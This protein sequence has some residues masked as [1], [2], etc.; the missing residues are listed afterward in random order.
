MAALFVFFSVTLYLL[1]VRRLNPVSIL[2]FVAVYSSVFIFL[3]FWLGVIHVPI[4]I[5]TWTCVAAVLNLIMLCIRR[6]KPEFA[7]LDVSEHTGTR[8][9]ISIRRRTSN[10][11]LI[12]GVIVALLVGILYFM[13]DLSVPQFV[14]IDPSL[15][16]V[17]ARKIDIDEKLQYFSGSIFYPDSA[18][19]RTYPYGAPVV[20][21]MI[22]SLTRFADSF[23]VFQL[24]QAFIFALTNG[25]ALYVFQK[26]FR[27][28]KPEIVIVSFFLITLGFFFNTMVFGFSSQLT[29]LFFMFA[30][31]D[32]YISFPWSKKKVILLALLMSAVMMTYFNWIAYVILFIAAENVSMVLRVG[33]LRYK[34]RALWIL[35]TA[36][37]FLLLSAHYFYLIFTSTLLGVITTSD[38]LAYK[39]FLGNVF[40]FLP[41]IAVYSF[42][43]VKNFVKQR[44]WEGKGFNMLAVSLFFTGVLG[45]FLVIGKFQMYIFAKSFYLTIP[46]MF[47]AGM[48]G[49]ER[50]TRENTP[51]LQVLRSTFL[52]MILFLILPPFF[53]VNRSYKL[54]EALPVRFD[55]LNVRP[56]DV[57]YYNGQN[58]I[59]QSI[60]PYN[61][62]ADMIEFSRQVQAQIPEGLPNNRISVVGHG[63]RCLWFYAFSDLWPR[64]IPDQLS[65]WNPTMLDWESWLISRQ[66]D[67]LVLLDDGDA[68]EW[69]ESS[70]FTWDLFEIVY[71]HGGNFL[72]KYRSN[73]TFAIERTT[74]CCLLSSR[75]VQTSHIDL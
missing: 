71:E 48:K 21:S 3:S 55:D 14:S 62:D 34:V 28:H 22:F 35:A 41:F 67:Y 58:M 73:S 46:V 10:F 16:Y 1:S 47:Y 31:F 29:G 32:I 18:N 19:L 60:H 15:H 38:G 61:F 56:L 49:L 69:M 44:H 59:N 64:D 27:I 50:V 23:T 4:H 5:N 11:L 45:F 33:W 66:S 8:L 37:M 43:Y 51:I 12:A 2:R 25:Y 63:N 75:S 20:T 9:R 36:V 54:S 72:L 70:G 39:V 26:L 7:L 40:I 24:L 68:R 13:N 53:I 57:F 65:L 30:C 52:V 42:P 74:T 6:I 17:F